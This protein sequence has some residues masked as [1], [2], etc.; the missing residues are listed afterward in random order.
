[1]RDSFTK[2]LNLINNLDKSQLLSIN[3]I[4]VTL[5]KQIEL[6]ENTKKASRFKIGDLV[7]FNDEHQK[8]WSGMVFKMALLQIA[9]IIYKIRFY[10]LYIV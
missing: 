6:Q 5:V 1:M 2:V 3:K 9:K 7:Y 8:K 10:I 4:I